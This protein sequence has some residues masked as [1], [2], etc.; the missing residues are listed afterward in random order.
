MCSLQLPTMPHSQGPHSHC[1]SDHRLSHSLSSSGSASESFCL[2]SCPGYDSDSPAFPS[3]QP[4]LKTK[5]WH[6]SKADPLIYSFA[7]SESNSENPSNQSKIM[8]GS[9]ST[10]RV[11]D[12]RRTPASIPAAG[13]AKD[14]RS[15]PPPLPI[16]FAGLLSPTLTSSRNTSARKV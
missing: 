10:S 16:P 5:P 8:D 14:I 9:M 6:I 15:A 3:I 2:S 11:I 12:L 7:W 1:H 4:N 13:V